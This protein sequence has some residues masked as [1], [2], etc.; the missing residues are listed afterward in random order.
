M[1]TQYTQI[2]TC[3][4]II[5]LTKCHF[6]KK[7]TF[8]THHR[9]QEEGLTNMSDEDKILISK[10]HAPGSTELLPTI[11]SFQNG[12]LRPDAA[13]RIDC[14]IYENA[15][16][17]QKCVAVLDGNMPYMGLE[18]PETSCQTFLAIR[19]RH[20]NEIQLVPVKKALLAPVLRKEKI[21][22]G[23]S[24]T[25]D[26]QFIDL[27]KNFG[28]K[29]TARKAEQRLQT[30]VGAVEDQLEA[31]AS[32]APVAVDSVNA[33]TALDMPE[34]FLPPCNRDAA[35]PR[36]VYKLSDIV[37]ETDLQDLEDEARRVLEAGEEEFKNSKYKYSP[38]YKLL[39]Q[40]IIRLNS[41]EEEK[42][43]K[44]CALTYIEYLIL[45]NR[46]R[47]DEASSPDFIACDASSI[48]TLPL[49]D[50]AT[51]HVLIL[52]LMLNKFKIPF[53]EFI[54][55]TRTKVNQLTVLCQEMC[56]TI[57][58]GE[59][60]EKFLTLKLPLPKKPVSKKMQSVQFQKRRR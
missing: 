30:N 44:L 28:S 34:D 37:S 12:S 18:I 10:V 38:L 36:D 1:A 21:K 4:L 50:K 55:S 42:I 32:Q 29:K 60:N 25:F 24:S 54:S 23:Q 33:L 46:I 43:R 31:S 49:M 48:R 11:V 3:M 5:E 53:G 9:G 40:R 13:K 56:V 14:G 39:F 35:K 41:S 16:T 7:Q 2:R 8:H 52:S 15:R 51:C 57:E 22:T 17:R 27:A 45:L 26:D 20:E 59:K 47:S 19:K 58:V 6:K